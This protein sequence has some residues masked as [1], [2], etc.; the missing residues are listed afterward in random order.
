MKLSLFPALGLLAASLIPTL[1]GAD[2]M[3][4]LILY[5]DDLGYGDLTSYQDNSKIPTPHLDQI[6]KEGTRFTDGHSSSGIC[7]PSRYALLTGRHHWRDFHGIVNAMGASVFPSERLTLPEMM[8]QSGYDTACIGKW[9]LGWDWMAIHTGDATHAKQKKVWEHT[10][11]DWSQEIPDGPLA[12]G[13]DHYF[14]DSVI[15]FPPY[16]WIR[17]NKVVTVPD[18]TLLPKNIKQKTK[19]GNWEV[20]PGPAMADWDFYQVLPTLADEGEKYLR[21]RKGQDK[22]F[23][24]FFPFPSPHAPIIPTDEFDGK[25]G[26]G[27]YGDFV[28]QTDDIVGRLIKALKESGE[29]E[30][31][32]IIFSADNGPEHYAYARDERFGHWSAEPFRGLKRDI[33]EGGHHVP[34]LIKWPGKTEAGTVEDALVSQIDIMATLA[35]YLDFPLPADAAEDSHDLVPLLDGSVEK[36]RDFHIHNT[37]KGKY[38]IRVGD[39]LYIDQPSG[40]HNG[41]KALAF[42]KRRNY[43][44]DDQ[45]VALYNLKEDI[46][47]RHNLAAKNPEKVA[48][49]KAEMKKIREQGYSAPRLKK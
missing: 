19:E 12:H 48:E 39:W 1:S 22:P 18:S 2:K 36:V 24:L 26:A 25:S 34:F 21:G 45:K 35:S 41:R 38:A 5:A 33:Y 9:H 15:N 11:F 20:R 14:G 47:Q 31:T 43:P 27:A 16:C 6:A 4:V 32:I 17:D 37:A 44:E 42:E 13:F 28:V 23:F 46:A 3:N 7:T 30:N 29:Y 10:D 49:M 40:N 8:Q